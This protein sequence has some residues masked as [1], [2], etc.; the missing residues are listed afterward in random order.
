[1]G[2]YR[3][4]QDRWELIYTLMVEKINSGPAQ[5]SR[6]SSVTTQRYTASQ[7]SVDAHPGL[8]LPSALVLHFSSP[9]QLFKKRFLLVLDIV[10]KGK[11][12]CIS[13]VL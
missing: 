5:L 12:V 13:Q 3:P 7:P 9:R 4:R 11:C 2:S 6:S 1:M 8:R 10:S